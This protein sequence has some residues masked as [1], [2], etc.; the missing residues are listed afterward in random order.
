VNLGLKCD[1]VLTMLQDVA[2]V[3]NWTLKLN[4]TQN[5]QLKVSSKS[6]FGN[7]F[8][9]KMSVFFLFSHQSKIKP[10]NCILVC[11]SKSML[12]IHL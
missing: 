7:V 6:L 10:L 8:E 11:S 5:L 9:W 2:R 1:L 12:Q 3:Y 4:I